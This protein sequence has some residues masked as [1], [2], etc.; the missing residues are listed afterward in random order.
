MLKVGGVL[1]TGAIGGAIVGKVAGEVVEHI[2]YL[3]AATQY[4][5]D[6]FKI[7]GDIGNILAFAGLIYGP[8]FFHLQL[9]EHERKNK[10]K[11]DLSQLEEKLINPN[12]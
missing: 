11:E 7:Q 1:A 3:N 2:P 5:I 6:F 12:D 8:N 9:I 10:L 4:V